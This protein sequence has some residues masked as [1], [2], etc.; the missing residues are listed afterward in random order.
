M[1][2]VPERVSGLFL[3]IGTKMKESL[4]ENLTFLESKD[5]EGREW[6]VALISAGESK[7]KGTHGYIRYYPEEVLKKALPLFEK[8]KAFAYEFKGRMEQ[9]FDHLPDNVRNMKPEGLARNQVGWFDKAR[10]GKYTDPETGKKVEGIL[11]H[12][13]VLRGAEWL[14]KNLLDAWQHSK[15][16]LGFSIDG[17]GSE[18]PAYIRNKVVDRVDEISDLHEVTVVTTPAAGGPILRLIASQNQKLMEANM[19]EHLIKMLQEKAPHLLEG[20][21]LEEIDEEGLVKLLDQALVE[22]KK[23]KDDEKKKKDEEEQQE[24]KKKKKK[25]EE[26]EKEPP[27]VESEEDKL[28]EKI[29]SLL[30]DKKYAEAAKLMTDL[31]EKKKKKPEGYGYPPPEKKESEPDPL[32]QKILALENKL[33]TI[34]S[35]ALLTAKLSESNLPQVTQ[36]KLRL[37]F[38]NRIFTEEELNT[39]LKSEQEYLAKLTESGQVNLPGQQIDVGSGE[40]EKFQLAMDGLFEGAD[41]LDKDKKKVRRFTSFRE[42]YAV[43]VGDPRAMFASPFSILSDCYWF[44][45]ELKGT[46]SFAESYDVER[47][48]R[49]REAYFRESLKTSDWAEILGDS[50]TRKMMKEW[51]D[52]DLQVW[53]KITSD[54]VPLR[55]FRTNRRMM[56]GGYG[57]LSSV[58]EQG[59]YQ[60]LTSPGDTESTYSAGKKGGIESLTM[61]MIANDD[62]GAIKKIPV[63]LGK[64]AALS[65]YRDIFDMFMNN[66]EQDGST[67]FGSA[68]RGN[69]ITTALSPAGLTEMVYTLRTLTRYGD[70]SRYLGKAAKPKYIL[71]PNELEE[72]ANRLYQDEFIREYTNNYTTEPN[73]NRGMAEPIVLDYW[74]DATDY[75][76]VADPKKA[77]TLEV[78]FF[79]GNEE[80]E[81][82][83][84]DQPNV[85]SVFSADK[86]QYKIRYIYGYCVLNYRSFGYSHQ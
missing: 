44:T 40:R 47:K 25:D 38:G 16:L 52:E 30:K 21:K 66:L 11:A 68:A 54:I 56:M 32:E 31:E 2:A 33:S 65:L 72:M 28:I 35:A 4:I 6:E 19:N 48:R 42:A 3:F 74:T 13:H 1:P 59:T 81:L 36:D 27:K 70:S 39:T 18:Q 26:E 86:V 15:E 14:R 85:G 9:L 60:E 22:A 34:S 82:F 71:V 46:A 64:A 53:R 8:A 55:D 79:N 24:A 29:R 5:P 80:P 67:T 51:A 37:Q 12:F 17:G 45:P 63:K 23:K 84:Q 77:P 57:T 62:V 10:Y 50:I 76:T 78:G 43:I 7:N 75:W 83:I 73:K 20:V 49:L 61:E 58:S 41:L 69:Y